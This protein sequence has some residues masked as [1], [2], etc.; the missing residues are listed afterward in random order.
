VNP[1]LLT[2]HHVTTLAEHL[3]AQVDAL[4]RDEFYNVRDGDFTMH[5]TTPY[6][7]AILI[8]GEKKNRMSVFLKLPELRYL[9]YIF[10]IVRNQL[11]I[12]TEAMADVMTYVLTTVNSSTF[13]EPSPTANRNILYYQL[14]VEV[15]TLM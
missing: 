7:T 3:P 12:Y 11:I 5:F 8:L 9:A 14:F 1:I 10:P 6:K 15:K 4:W 13:V 2:D